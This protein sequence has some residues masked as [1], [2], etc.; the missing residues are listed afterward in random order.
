[1]REFSGFQSRKLFS[2]I[3]IEAPEILLQLLYLLQFANLPLLQM[4][5][6]AAEFCPCTLSSLAVNLENV[7]KFP[8][9]L[10]NLSDAYI[11]NNEII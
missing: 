9:E 8:P 7:W 11:F 6:S 5:N 3:V 2:L 10:G 1:M 4:C